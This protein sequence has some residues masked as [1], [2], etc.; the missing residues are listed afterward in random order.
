MGSGGSVP[1]YCGT[2]EVQSTGVTPGCDRGSGP[3]PS[4]PLE[5][6]RTA[7][8]RWLILRLSSAPAL[9]LPTLVGTLRR[10]G[11][12]L[13]PVVDT[14]ASL[15]AIV[16]HADLRAARTAC[17]GRISG[18]EEG[19]RPASPDTSTRRNP[20]YRRSVRIGVGCP[21]PASKFRG[22]SHP[23]HGEG[24]FLKAVRVSRLAGRARCRTRGRDV[25][26]APGFRSCR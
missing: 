5:A 17:T 26:S 11:V 7:G 2:S 13:L 9:L 25:S 20:S 24:R 12:P 18:L 6:R 21:I 22:P 10:S 4:P 16:G 23:R 3:T 8:K 19:L 14:R 1:G 15:A